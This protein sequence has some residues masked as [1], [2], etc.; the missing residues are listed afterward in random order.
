[1]SPQ[2]Q[3]IYELLSAAAIAYA[4]LTQPN[5]HERATFAL[6]IKDLKALVEHRMTRI[7][8]NLFAPP[9]YEVSDY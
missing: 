9:L 2:E 7:K 6:A 8:A 1:M 5:F 3:E 4:A